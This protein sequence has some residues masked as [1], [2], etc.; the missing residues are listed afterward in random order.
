MP[1]NAKWALNSRTLCNQ[2]CYLRPCQTNATDAMVAATV[3]MADICATPNETVL[4]VE[5][6]GDWRAE[7]IEMITQQGYR[8]IGFPSAKDMLG[9]VQTIE[10][11]CVLLDVRLP[12]Q[13]GL[14][15]QEWLNSTHCTLPVVFISGVKD[16]STIV[17]CMKAGAVEFLAKPIAEITLRRSVDLAVGL[18][19]K[20]HCMKESKAM[21]R[22][23]LAR[24]TPTEIEVARL[25]ARGYP[26]KMI[27]AEFGRSE[28][29]IKIH[30]HRIFSKLRVN[31]AA[32]IGS[33]IAHSE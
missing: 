2:Q 31:S 7:L 24:L 21:A 4:V 3:P 9:I 13:D 27:A 28:N 14:S 20:R 1:A 12:G 30:R 22:V 33:L 8:A 29:T 23:F 19:R 17:Q 16:I 26:T 15:V 25:I 18:S 11:G 5:D 6:D 32:S 10:T